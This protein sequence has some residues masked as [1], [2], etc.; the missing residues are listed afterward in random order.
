MSLD[1][2]WWFPERISNNILGLYVAM[3][4]WMQVILLTTAVWTEK[5]REQP[6][7]VLDNIFHDFL[8]RLDSPHRPNYITDWSGWITA[9]WIIIWS[10]RTLNIS[11]ELTTKFN[12]DI[13]RTILRKQS[14]GRNSSYFVSNCRTQFLHPPRLLSCQIFSSI[15]RAQLAPGIHAWK[16]ACSISPPQ[17]APLTIRIRRFCGWELG[18]GNGVSPNIYLLLLTSWK[19]PIFSMM[20]STGN[21]LPDGFTIITP[22]FYYLRA[23]SKNKGKKKRSRN[24]TNSTRHHC[25]LL[26]WMPGMYR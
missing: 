17:G 2:Y 22:L 7:I 19:C 24:N 4:T 16:S 12:N 25:E 3:R 18:K 20:Y 5:S 11:G 21:A 23:M 26:P 14:P 6:A 9:Y 10:C 8:P 15:D 1:I 13:L